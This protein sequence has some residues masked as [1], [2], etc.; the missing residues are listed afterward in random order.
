M[1]TGIDFIQ[2]LQRDAEFRR[3]VHACLQS[4]ECLA[5][6]KK[7]G[8][9]FTKFMQIIKQLSLWN[10]PPGEVTRPGGTATPGKPRLGFLA[11]LNQLFR[12]PPAPGPDR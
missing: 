6:L 10:R 12:A 3:Q 5:F 4:K 1:K 7:A 2:R 9:D 8:Y 11:R